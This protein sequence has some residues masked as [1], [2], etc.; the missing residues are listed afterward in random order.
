MP[1]VLRRRSQYR[2]PGRSRQ[3]G[4]SFFRG[5]DQLACRRSC[6]SRHA[7]DSRLGARRVGQ[8]LQR[9]GLLQQGEQLRVQRGAGDVVRDV[10]QAARGGQRGQGRFPPRQGLQV[11]ETGFAPAQLAGQVEEGKVGVGVVA[12]RAHCGEEA[13]VTL[14]QRRR[15][16]DAVVSQATRAREVQ[17]REQHADLVRAGATSAD[18][19]V[20]AAEL[21]LIGGEGHDRC[22]KHILVL[23]ASS[24]AQHAELTE[25]PYRQGDFELPDDAHG[26]IAFG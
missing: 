11:P 22:Y 2:G 6:S 21:V 26:S 24:A 8:R 7:S 18:I 14:Q 5:V 9:F 20:K 12:G 19:D 13:L 10:A 4:R 3:P 15:E 17:Q 16:Q 25:Q 1:S 23:R